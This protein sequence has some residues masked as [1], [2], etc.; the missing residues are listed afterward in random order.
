M[1]DYDKWDLHFLR[2]AR[3][4]SLMSKDPSSKLGCIVAKD[5]RTVGTGYNG[6]P[7][8]VSDDHRLLDRE[9]KYKL[10]V[11]AE[12][13]AILDAGHQAQGA[14][15]YL[16]GLSFVCPECAKHAIAAGIQRVVACGGAIPKRW[17]E[18]AAF[19]REVW[20]EVNISFEEIPE[21]AVEAF[22]GELG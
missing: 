3:E 12:M 10:I 13:N 9:I 7:R 14:T 4:A 15:L 18:G 21:A 16:Y 17:E 22:C 6:F 1:A 2:L 8:G 11:H 19:T 20:Q 5:R